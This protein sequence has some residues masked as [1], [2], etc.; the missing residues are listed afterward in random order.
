[1]TAWGELPTLTIESRNEI[2]KADEQDELAV[3]RNY[4]K[5]DPP[6]CPGVAF[7]ECTDDGSQ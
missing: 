6:S 4:E 7:S 3:S 1:M 5:G 2:K